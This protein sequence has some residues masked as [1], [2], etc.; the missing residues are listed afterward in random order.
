MLPF[1]TKNELTQT[2]KYVFAL[3]ISPSTIKGAIWTVINDQ[4]QVVAVSTSVNWDDKTEDSLITAC[5][6]VLTDATARLDFTGKMQLNEVIFGLCSDWVEDDKVKQSKLVLLKALSA[7]LELKP[8]GFVVTVEAITKY[9]HRSEGVPST[10]ILLGFWPRDLEVTL[11][12]MGK[13]D[14]SHVVR[15]SSHIAS[16]VVEGLSRYQNIDVMPSRMLLYDSGLNLEEIKQM[17]LDH[18][19]QTP[20][21]K[22]PFLH[23][24]KIEILPAD[25]TVRAIALA[26]GEEVARAIGMLEET[27]ASVEEQT[28]TPVEIP[29]VS[30]TGF[31]EDVDVS[32]QIQSHSV[33]TATPVTKP[34]IA[35]P[36]I[37]L[38]KFNLQLPKG[39]F[40]P[41][42]IVVAT[43]LIFLGLGI[44][45]WYLPK[46]TVILSVTP[47]DFSTQF[48]VTV[49]PSLSSVDIVSA[50]IP[51]ELL[52]ADVSAE[53]QVTT[54]GTKLV[55]DKATG[56]VVISNA[57]DSARTFPAG[58]VLTSPSGLKFVLDEAVT[59]A[60]ASG[61]AGNLVPG[62]SSVK[63][64][65]SQIGAESNLSAGTVFRVANLA[66]TQVDAKNDTALSGGTS[67]Q[68]KAVA[69]AD[70][71]A[72]LEK[73]T[74]LLK[75]QAR[76]RLLEQVSQDKTVVAE[77][78]SLK[79][80]TQQFSAKEGDEAEI[81]R[82]N[83]VVKASGLVISKS[84]LQQIVDEKIGLQTPQGYSVVAESSQSFAVKDTK[85]DK[86]ILS[87]NVSAQLLPDM[88]K[89]QIATIIRG[90]YPIVAREYLE[91]L[92][93]VSE[94]AFELDP[95]L[96]GFL[97]VIPRVL[98][99]ITI[100]VQSTMDP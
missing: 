45:Y 17:L 58:T 4:T 68:A 1:L 82:L 73:M 85:R 44:A 19:W 60:S 54:T 81:L 25:F 26:G 61:S 39:K 89:N 93:G 24:P 51:G 87:A 37:S 42:A 75:Q 14:G 27:S 88:D 59:V 94:V 43:L 70:V 95:P 13:T 29:V 80:T 7:K 6:Q 3:E 90:K 57:L 2:R 49:D 40:V 55:G 77:S 11:V 35:L 62:K 86:T 50:A 32:T 9:L 72:L 63:I 96:P 5:D 28:E 33:V 74:T 76:E 67:R 15:R 16:D 38:P 91:T 69:K 41:T 20:N 30:S 36:H 97:A 64:S 66:V 56:S 22:L 18:P 84:D 8:V 34:S 98:A 92:P 48:E 46:A 79:T 10:A 23:F 21:K 100:T 71:T 83:M 65:A 78:I 12:R 99:N 52:T 31:V 47:K 53:D